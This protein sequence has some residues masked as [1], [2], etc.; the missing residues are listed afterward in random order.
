MAIGPVAPVGAQTQ[1]VRTDVGGRQRA[2]A[3]GTA[4][5]QQDRVELS[6]LARQLAGGDGPKLQLDPEQLRELVAPKTSP[7]RPAEPAAPA[8]AATAAERPAARPA[9]AAS[10]ERSTPATAP[11]P[12]AAPEA[13]E[14][15]GP[16]GPT[17]S[18]KGR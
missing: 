9:D 14:R 12:K 1:S 10:T 7:V 4:S 3:D 16:S 17:S 13:S 8:S 15:R 2:P 11:D 5:T 18:T 6:P